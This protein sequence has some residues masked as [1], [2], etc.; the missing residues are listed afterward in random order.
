M[1][2]LVEL[3][4]FECTVLTEAKTRPGVLMT[5]EGVFQRADT[6]NANNRVYPAK[7]WNKL[8]TDEE[9]NERIVTR[10]MFGELDHPAGG[11]TSGV[12]VSHIVTEHRLLPS[13]EVRGK[14]DILDT[15]S[16]RIAET[17]FRAGAR[18]GVSSR[19]DGSVERKG[20]T[21]EVQEDFR[22]ET[23]D[24]VLKPSTPGAYPQIVESEEAAK[25][26]C[27]LIAEAVSG[28]VNSTTDVGVLL[29]CHKILSVLESARCESIITD[30]KHKLTGPKTEGSSTDPKETT[31]PMA[32]QTPS[33]PEHSSDQ[34]TL[35]LREQIERGIVENKTLFESQIAT[36]NQ[37]VVDL[38]TERDELK[39]DLEAA[40]KL[41]EE[42]EHATKELK[43]A[44]RGDEKLQKQ[45]EAA[46]KLLDEAVPR[47][48]AAALTE[49]RLEAS[50]QLLAASIERHQDEA[51][52]RVVDE[53]LKDIEESVAK[54]LRPL[55]E[56]CA[57][58]AE[59][60]EQFTRLS[61]LA[62]K[63]QPLRETEHEPLPTKENRGHL[64]EHQQPS[65]RFRPKQTQPTGPRGY[66][67]S[68]INQ[69]VSG[70]AR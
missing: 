3:Q 35:F 49:R 17:L 29:E 7:L 37:R 1:E 55:L 33:S 38:V 22:L 46:L 62:L 18:L 24:L 61:N 4:P 2:R 15:P 43:E 16:G 10:S 26:N 12:R 8:M 50:K 36:L 54:E 9:L 28:L 57:T 69:L 60:E 63:L 44:Q 67:A 66:V 51:V 39:T 45:Y 27:D 21:S 34:T 48:Q 30:L 58:P 31:K 40:T 32:T 23:Y 19:G 25:Q 5:V 59:V 11:A 68:T 70:T 13:G 20:D 41:I 14:I 64:T 65:G 56:S 53:K 47:L 42:F 6:K 52:V